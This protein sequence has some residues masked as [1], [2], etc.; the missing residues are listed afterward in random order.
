[1][2]RRGALALVAAAV[3]VWVAAATAQVP[4]QVTLATNPPGTTFYA[5][6]SGLAKVVT[7]HA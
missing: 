5:V 3:L 2:P 4:K 7:A 6:A 1:M